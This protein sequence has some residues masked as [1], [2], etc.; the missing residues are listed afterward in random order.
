MEGFPG[1]LSAV[2]VEKLPAAEAVLMPQT[3]VDQ[4]LFANFD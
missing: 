2:P 1:E 3:P 4:V